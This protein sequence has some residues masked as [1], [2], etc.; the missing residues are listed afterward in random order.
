[1]LVKI[2]KIMVSFKFTI[3]GNTGSDGEHSIILLLIKERNNTS[4]S[5]RKKCKYKDWSFE[6]ER[7]K[8]SHKDYKQINA[9]IN[10]YSD[11]IKEIINE[12]ELDE[13][14]FTLQD[15]I[16][17]FKKK[18]GKQQTLSYTVF[19][20]NLIAEAKDAGKISTSNIEKETLK[21]V[22]RFMGKTEISFRDLSVDNIYKY[23]SFLNSNNNSQSTIGIRMRTLRAV[24]NKAIKRE[25]IPA[26]MY[27]F[28]KFKVSKIKE[29]GK[30]EYLTE[31]ELELLKFADLE[32][33]HENIARDMFLLSFY[34]RGINFI[35]LMQLQKTDLYKGTITYRRRKTGVMVSFK[36][37][38]FWEQKIVEYSAKPES[39]YLFNIINNEQTNENYIE[40]RKEKYLKKYIN[41][42]LK[43]VM[44]K[45]EIPKKITYYCARHSFATILKFNNISIDII[46]E[47]LGHKD[48]KS[49]MSYLN[50]LP[51]NTLD[52]MIDDVINF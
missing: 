32:S 8:K 49:T 16:A 46:K 42:P 29:S 30:K 44:T 21:S 9:L 2:D 15:I 12:F 31:P 38:D 24:F 41:A 14:P 20:E 52:K 33:K 3:K 50:T 28:D 27:P 39:I 25:I 43:K 1:M 40:N 47:A 34:G 36:V 35:D 48:I 7:L 23:Q 13:S 26:S 22:Q 10:K 45:L 51:S 5:I 17:Q 4:L 37:N 19:H 18:S 11:R 6:T